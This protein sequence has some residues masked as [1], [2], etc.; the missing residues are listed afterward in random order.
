MNWFQLIAALL[1]FAESIFQ[2]IQDALNAGKS[3]AQVHNAILDHTAQLASKI[4]E[5]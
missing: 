3:Q 1:P 2:A 5:A 4:R